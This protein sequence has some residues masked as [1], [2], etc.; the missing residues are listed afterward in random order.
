[1]PI[2][3]VTD[4]GSDLPRGM[5]DELGISVVPLYIYFGQDGYRDGVNL[6]PDEFFARLK[7]GPVH[8]TTSGPSPSDFAQVYD[9]LGKDCAGIVSI[10]ISGKLSGTYAAAVLGKEMAANK[11]CPIE[12]ID[13]RLVTIPLGLV[14]LE[15][16]RA[17]AGAKS[18]EEIRDYVARLIPAMRSYGILDTLKYIVKGGRLSKASSLVGS[19]LPVRP[20]LTIKDGSVIPV[21]VSRTRSGAIENLIERLRAV[22]NVIAIG[23][24]HSTSNEE[25]ASFTDRLKAFLPDIKPLVVGLGP[26]IGTHG[27]PGTILV[28]LQQDLSVTGTD[29][30]AQRK[31]AIA[32][33]SLQSI[34]EGILQR[35]QRAMK[36]F[37]LVNPLPAAQ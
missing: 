2:R 8:P 17:A 14:A 30:E 20:I 37:S 36:R 26:A 15:A 31:W 1:M 28:A 5:A 3:I 18:I 19:L 25:M 27:G 12:V 6:Q 33:P 32:L 13:S 24:A 9:Q 10:H 16:A 23:I 22:T 34:K 4:S 29:T 7:A 35:R 11:T 21:G